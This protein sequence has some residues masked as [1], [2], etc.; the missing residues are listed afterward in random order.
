MKILDSDHC[1]AILRG[2][3][4][5]TRRVAHGEELATT[6]VSVGALVHGAAKSQRAAENLTRLDV[7]LA[8][9][10]ILPYDEW[11]AHRFGA[12]KAELERAGE[13][14]GDLDL[15]IASIAL[16]QNATLVTHNKRHFSRVVELAGL[17]ID[18]WL[19]D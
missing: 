9:L 2:R 4:D 6:T 10:T 8:A 7:L 16:E 3:L 5:L 1:I 19:V 14:I 12:L 15:Q 17:E 13:V 18:D 11:S